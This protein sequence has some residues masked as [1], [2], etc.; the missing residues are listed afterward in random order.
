MPSGTLY[1]S[2]TVDLQ[3]KVWQLKVRSGRV[4]EMELVFTS[5]HQEAKTESFPPPPG[6][7]DR[8]V[9]EQLCTALRKSPC[10]R[11]KC[12]HATWQNLLQTK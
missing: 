6:R 3:G 4:T 9:A 11:A 10:T 7:A 1:S 12:T 8:K 5:I 2:V